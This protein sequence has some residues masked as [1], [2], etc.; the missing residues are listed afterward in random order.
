M[1]VSLYVDV[2]LQLCIHSLQIIVSMRN[3]ATLAPSRKRW[4][5]CQIEEL[6]GI[7][8]MTRPAIRRIPIRQTPEF[9]G[10]VVEEGAVEEEE[11]EGEKEEEEELEA[12]ERLEKRLTITGKAEAV[13][14]IRGACRPARAR[15]IEVRVVLLRL[16]ESLERMLLPYGKLVTRAFM[17]FYTVPSLMIEVTN[18][19]ELWRILSSSITRAVALL[20]SSAITDADDYT[21]GLHDSLQLML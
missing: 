13:W 4:V 21:I 14:E 2:A 5:I 18:E 9:R 6:K 16:V 11:G 1:Y 19:R 12:G 17:C 7:T 8:S 10:V 3:Q 20:L 15:A